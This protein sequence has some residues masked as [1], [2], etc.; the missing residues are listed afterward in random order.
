[1]TLASSGRSDEFEPAALHASRAK[2]SRKR[3][4]GVHMHSEAVANLEAPAPHRGE[5]R[6]VAWAREGVIGVLNSIVGE[7]LRVAFIDGLRDG[8]IPR[9]C[10]TTP[11]SLWL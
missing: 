8:T 10:T 4:G 3:V 11:L 7:W 5:G 6:R 1:M 2:G 9:N